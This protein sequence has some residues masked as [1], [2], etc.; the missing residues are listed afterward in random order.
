MFFA[1]FEGS[2]FLRRLKCPKLWKKRG[3]FS[4]SSLGPSVGLFSMEIG[5]QS[6]RPCRAVDG[7]GGAEASSLHQET[8]FGCR[9]V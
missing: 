3:A 2:P 8:G 5:L 9:L 4:K 7:S 1:G 6:L